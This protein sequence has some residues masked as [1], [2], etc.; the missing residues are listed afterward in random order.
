MRLLDLF[1]GAGGAAMGYSQAGFTQIVGVDIVPQ[2]NYPF[3]FIQAD[4]L[5]PSVDLDLFDLVHAS[6]PCQAFTVYGN[7]KARV[8]SD[9]PDLIE[10][11]RRLLG[12]REHVIENVQG[13]PLD[14]TVKLCGTAFGIEV[15]RHRLF[16]ASFPMLAPSCY[17]GRYTERKYPGSSNRPR[18]RTV[19]NIG[20]WRVPLSQQQDAMQI[21]WMTLPELS[22]AIPP[23]YTRFIGEQFL[24]QQ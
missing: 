2:R 18:G 22:E 12:D 13:A 20:E 6:P 4:A 19:A 16:E 17:H 9:H 5:N 7:N 21:D 10:P 14:A 24:A 15:R 11:T 23:V 3:T 1:C 8:R